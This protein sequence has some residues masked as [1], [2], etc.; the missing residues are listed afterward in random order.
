MQFAYKLIKIEMSFI[1]KSILSLNI[2]LFNVLYNFT[3]FFKL[4]NT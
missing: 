1:I 3:P 4:F 2:Y